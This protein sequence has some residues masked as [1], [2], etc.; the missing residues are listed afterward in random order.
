MST[1][2]PVAR[3]SLMVFMR[4]F[5]L[6]A[7]L[8]SSKPLLATGLIQLSAVIVDERLNED[9]ASREP[10]LYTYQTRQ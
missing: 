2:A 4:S 7:Y 1:A 8:L 3:M 5:L 10:C 6:R 9:H